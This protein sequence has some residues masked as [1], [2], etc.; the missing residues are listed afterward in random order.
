MWRWDGCPQLILSIRFVLS[1][2]PAEASISSRCGLMPANDPK[3]PSG[4]GNSK[5]GFRFKTGIGDAAKD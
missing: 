4:V 1:P 5:F 2:F 3:R